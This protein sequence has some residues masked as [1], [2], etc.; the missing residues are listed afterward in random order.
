MSRMKDRHLEILKCRDAK[1]KILQNFLNVPK[2][3]RRG[4]VAAVHKDN[5]TKIARTKFLIKEIYKLHNVGG[6]LHIVL[7]DY[8]IEDHHI[9]YCLDNSIVTCWYHNL[10][11]KD[12]ELLKKYCVECAENLLGMSYTRRKKIVEN[13]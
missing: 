4:M 3:V 13:N 5:E 7:D 1:K 10:S 11:E 6:P 2:E 9:T 8:N 12:N